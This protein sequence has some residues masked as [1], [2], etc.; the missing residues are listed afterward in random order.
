LNVRIEPSVKVERSA[1]R[2]SAGVEVSAEGVHARVWA[3]ACRSI[4]V[5][6]EPRAAG[7][8]RTL[9]LTRDAEGFFEGPIDAR[10]G[11]R[12]W[13]RLNGT[14]LR[15]DPASRFQPDGPHGP[16]EIIDPST[17]AWTD[18]QWGGVTAH[19]QV[20]YE[21]HVG[22]FTREGTW[23]AAMDELPALAELGITLIEMMPVA[24]F[25]GRFGWGYDGVDLYAPTH[26]YGR[27][28][29][30]RAFIDRAHALGIGVIL[31]V[32]YNHVG[33][34]GNYL[35]EFS[36]DYFTDRYR[37]DWGQALN[38]EGPAPARLFFVENAGYWVEEF[39]FDGL[40]LDATQDIHDASSEHVIAS[41]VR[42]V[43]EVGGSRRTFVV[44]ENEPQQPKLVRPRA[45]GGYG[46]DALWNDD[47]HHTAIVALTGI[48]EAY[49]TDYKGAPQEFISAAKYGYLYQGQWYQWQ[50]N[51]RGQ[52]DL[53]L[54]GHAYVAYLE[55]HDQIANTPFG[56]RL[57]QLAAPARLRALT[58]FMLLG[59]A[60]PML[61]QGQEFAASAPFL[62]FAD[63][64]PE[65]NESIRSGRREFLGQFP[66]VRDPELTPLLPSPVD[67]ST[68]ERCKLDLG[69]RE[70]HGQAYALH[71][72]LLALRK[73]DPVIRRAAHERPDGA[74]L[75]STAFLLRYRGGEDG[76]RLLIVNLGCD[77]DL[78]P[79]PEPLLAPPAETEWVLQWSSASVR[80]GGQGRAPLPEDHLHV[81]GDTTVLLKSEPRATTA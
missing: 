81:P 28:D 13:F 65:L 33:P 67:P 61:F 70:R 38:F 19:G 55:N 49:Y 57:H 24:E 79:L 17:F 63:H 26:L 34:D 68:F 4:D 1:R 43:R 76:D 78:L 62:Y 30:L 36:P 59:P 40:R 60:T 74:V 20:V 47:F 48:R 22:T 42:R 73:S 53:E 16:S 23:R 44:A 8:R 11:D 58:A 3:P 18:A 35:A 2:L 9:P 7:S 25:A 10:A 29:D 12:Y 56:R 77:L 45:Q 6:L 46:A 32:V 31:D 72:D 52:P 21:L 15:P 80:Y 64:K 14:T 51:R 69:E 71:R 39:H 50:K 75:S 37:N 54:P 66:S 27:P 5:V 41:I